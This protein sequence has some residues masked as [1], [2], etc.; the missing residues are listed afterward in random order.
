[1]A[2]FPRGEEVAEIP[3]HLRENP[4]AGV[5]QG[6]AS[7]DIGGHVVRKIIRANSGALVSVGLTAEAGVGGRA[8]A[9]DFVAFADVIT[10]IAQ[11]QGKRR[12]RGV[13]HGAL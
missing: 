8:R 12:D 10:V 2:R 4:G 13:P 3:A 11:H 6:R 9:P 5:G 7:C 1:L